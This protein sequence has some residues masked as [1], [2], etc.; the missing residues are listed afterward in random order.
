MDFVINPEQAETVRLIFDL[1]LD[2]WGLRKIKDELERRGRKTSQGMDSWD[3]TVISH[4]LKNT[5][6]CGILTYHK[7]YTPDYLKQKKVKI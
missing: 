3:P 1:Y 6:Y 4:I 5:F 2:G 7:E